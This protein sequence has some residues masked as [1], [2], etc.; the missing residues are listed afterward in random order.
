MAVLPGGYAAADG[1]ELVLYARGRR[2]APKPA[3]PVA[4]ATAEIRAPAAAR[5][6]TV[7][8]RDVGLS[9]R[10]QHGSWFGGR[11]GGRDFWALR[12][13]SFTAHEG[14]ALGI[15]GCNGSGKSSLCM[16]LAGTMRPDEGQVVTRGRVQLLAL[17]VGFQVDLSGRE[18]VYISGTLLGLTRNQI[19]EKIDDIVGFS[20]LGDFIDEPVRTYS[21]GMRSRLAFAVATA[22]E[23]EILLL[24]E[25]MTAGDQSFS[26]KAAARLEAMRAAARTIIMVTHNLSQ[27]QHAC[28][29]V[30]WLDRGRLLMDG[31]PAAVLAQYREFSRDR[32]RWLAD[33]PE[34]VADRRLPAAGEETA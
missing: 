16:L 20:E 4:P 21:A 24:D 13:V 15:V 28:S 18:N 2:L 22:I 26:G 17:G 32:D 3:V 11:Q 7:T 6:A 19:A 12:N 9:Y 30:I 31:E 8:V 10:R 25:V 33:H 1:G 29:R 27:M 34:I 5:V 14:E 23:P